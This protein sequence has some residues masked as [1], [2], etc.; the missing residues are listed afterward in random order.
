M[1]R[2]KW[3]TFLCVF[4]VTVSMI[5]LSF[6]EANSTNQIDSKIKELEEEQKKLNSKKSKVTEDKRE[7]EQ[8]MTDNKSS[9]K[10]VE[11]QMTEIESE[12]NKTESEIKETTEAIAETET[13]I[14]ELEQNIRKLN[15][16]IKELKER[17]SLREELLKERLRSIQESGGN[18]KYI[19]VLFGSQSFTDLITRSSAVNAIMDQDK[20]IMEEH[21]AD[22][23]ALEE[24]QV[25]VK[26]KK[27]EVEL[28]K[29]KQE[30]Q[31]E[32]LEGLKNKLD[33]QKAEKEKI[34]AQ[35]EEEF[36]ELEE[37]NLSLEEEQAIISNQALALEKAKKLAEEEK[38]NAEAEEKAKAQDNNNKATSGGQSGQPAPSGGSGIFNRPMNGYLTSEFRSPNRP[39]HHGIDIGSNN[40]DAPIYAAASGVVT[41]AYY[42]STYGNVVFI[43]HV[44]NGQRYETVYAHLKYTPLVSTHQT[45]K[46]GQQIGVM[47]NTGASRGAHLHFEIHKGS[48]NNQK[49][50]AVNPLSY[51][52]YQYP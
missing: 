19:T 42:S 52:S 51:V 44:I 36:E 45:V 32:N 29:E 38:K 26:E 30:E 11:Q 13:E 35:L 4:I 24:K 47:G 2:G 49:S 14:D 23:L 25:E 31:K 41:N 10:T 46:Q 40:K 21:A 20:N 22:Q 6:V 48:W 5:N 43:T 12:L 7:V 3:L 34:K 8:K 17:I 39:S 27:K 9:Q 28:Q 15:E 50:N 16:E 37:Y 1:I 33:D 18:V